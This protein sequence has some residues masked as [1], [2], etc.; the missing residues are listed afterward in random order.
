[1]SFV[2]LSRSKI[3]LGSRAGRRPD[4]HGGKKQ[5]APL[6]CSIGEKADTRPLHMLIDSIR[7]TNAAALP[8]LADVWFICAPWPSAIPVAAQNALTALGDAPA[9]G[10][11]YPV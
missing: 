3:G 4:R 2:L 11:L 6:L 5:R 1:M 10:W 9:K 7:A 8:G